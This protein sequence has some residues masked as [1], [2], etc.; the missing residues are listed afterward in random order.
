RDL[1][2]GIQDTHP[3]PVYG[4]L[5]ERPNGP[6]LDTLVSLGNVEK[7][8]RHFLNVLPPDDAAEPGAVAGATFGP[9]HGKKDGVA[10]PHTAAAPTT[11]TEPQ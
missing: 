10:A 4:V 2:S 6:C 1:A 7:A 3:I 9:Q 8:L 11:P 5:N